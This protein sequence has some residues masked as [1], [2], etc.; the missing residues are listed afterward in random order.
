M[1]VH[2]DAYQLNDQIHPTSTWPGE[3][4]QRQNRT[5][6]GMLATGASPVACDKQNAEA[7]S[8]AVLSLIFSDE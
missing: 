7:G 3:Q 6:T 5:A 8:R 2:D 1:H 4:F